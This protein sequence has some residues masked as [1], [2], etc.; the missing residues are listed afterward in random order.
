MR[1]SRQTPDE[2]GDPHAGEVQGQEHGRGPQIVGHGCGRSGLAPEE[3]GEADGAGDG[4]E[5]QG[6][7][8]EA[9]HLR[10]LAGPTLAGCRATSVQP[11]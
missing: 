7:G 5:G 8:G 6:S 1:G 11:R 10:N 2:A 9:F 4:G 3:R